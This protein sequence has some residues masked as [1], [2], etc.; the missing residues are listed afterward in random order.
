MFIITLETISIVKI[1]TIKL[2]YNF[3]IFIQMFF[4]DTPFLSAVTLK[5]CSG[6]MSL[7][8]ELYIYCFAFNHIDNVVIKKT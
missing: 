6:L 5:Y 8:I 3:L 7:T 1:V 4:K 2:V